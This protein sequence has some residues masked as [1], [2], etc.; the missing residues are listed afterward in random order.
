MRPGGAIETREVYPRG[1]VEG[2][3]MRI[4]DAR[5]YW[6]RQWCRSTRQA[7]M[8][9]TWGTRSTTR[10]G[11]TRKGPMPSGAGAGGG[12]SRHCRMILSVV[13][14][15]QRQCQ[16]ARHGKGRFLLPVIL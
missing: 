9:T 15:R 10:G 16:I 6:D 1:D 11:G 8:S 14:E 4:S 12:F 3:G 5:A 2:R 7:S 13:E